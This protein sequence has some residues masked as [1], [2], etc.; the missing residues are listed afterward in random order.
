MRARHGRNGVVAGGRADQ[1]AIV[2]AGDVGQ[3]ALEQPIIPVQRGHAV[4]FGHRRIV[5]RGVDEIEERVGRAGLRHDRLADV[6]DLRGVLP[7][8]MNAKN[9]QRFAM[10]QQLEHAHGL[11]GD[12]RR[13]RLL[14]SAW[15]IS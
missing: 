10:E 8:A 11:A 2:S 15:P 1:A 5:E 9:L 12:L 14:N 7:K 3:R 6:D 4:G 13:A